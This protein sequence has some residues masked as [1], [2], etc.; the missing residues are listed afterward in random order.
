MKKLSIQFTK[1]F[2]AAAIG[3]TVDFGT[4][5]LCKEVLG[6]HYLASSSAGFILGLIAVYIIS[7]RYVFGQSKLSSRKREFVAF[8]VI[9]VMGL[10]ILNLIMWL[11]TDGVH[12]NYLVSKIFATVVV[13]IWNF[14]A[15]RAMYNN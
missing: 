10:G 7:T 8:A 9:G 14:F 3:Y 13:Y 15:R 6:L 5:L 11:L 4:L 1:Y 12:I 2:G